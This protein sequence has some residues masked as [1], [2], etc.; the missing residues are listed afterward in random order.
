MPRASLFFAPPRLALRSPPLLS[1]EHSHAL[2]SSAPRPCRWSRC[3]PLRSIPSC[4]TAGHPFMWPWAATGPLTICKALCSDR[5]RFTQMQFCSPQQ[6]ADAAERRAHPRAREG[7]GARQRR[8]VAD[9]EVYA[10]RG[11]S[12]QSERSPLSGRLLV[13]EENKNSGRGLQRKVLVIS[14]LLI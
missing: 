2:R 11:R 1:A 7:G 9:H 14:E 5:Q 10:G 3:L 6:T 13:A 8:V 12:E 4:L